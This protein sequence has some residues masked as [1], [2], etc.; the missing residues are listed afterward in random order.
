MLVPLRSFALA[1]R[2]SSA[3]LSLV[4]EPLFRGSNPASPESTQ[5]KA[6]FQVLFFNGGESGIRTP[7]GTHAPR[8]I[9]SQVHSTALPT[10]HSGIDLGF[11]QNNPKGQVFFLYFLKLFA[12]SYQT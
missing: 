12:F 11:T 10:L 7:G 5:K 9:S 8:L 4:V 6:P 1:H 3:R 2:R